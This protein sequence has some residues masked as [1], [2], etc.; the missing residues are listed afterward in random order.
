[1]DILFSKNLKAIRKI[2]N[3]TQD[4]AATAL[5]LKRTT[6]INWESGHSQPDFENILIIS[7]KFDISIDKLLTSDLSEVRFEDGKLV[8]ENDEKGKDSGKDSGKVYQENDVLSVVSKPQKGLIYPK[9]ITVDTTGNE[10]CLYVPVKARAGY[11]SGHSDPKFIE[12][13]PAYRL[14]NVN[15]GTFRIFEVEGHSMFNTFH[16]KDKAIGRWDNFSNIKDGRIY[17]LVTKNDGLIIKR[18]INRASE[19]V[20]ICKSDNNYKGEYP[21]IVLDINEILEVWYVTDKWTKQMGEPGEIYSR[22]IEME[23]T[24]ILQGKKLDKLMQQ[25]NQT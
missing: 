12:T 3:L 23:A 4:E 13:L 20:I 15:N 22:M 16:D 8:F 18:L 19:G 11:L 17:V 21:P 7:S 1:M 25:F 14:P 24:I 10:N 2:Q 9:V 5:G 6:Y